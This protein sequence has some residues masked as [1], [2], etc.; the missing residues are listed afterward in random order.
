M[1]FFE[2]GLGLF[3]LQGLEVCSSLSSWSQHVGPIESGEYTVAVCYPNLPLVPST[4][5]FGVG[6]RSEHGVEDYLP[7][8]FELEI[9]HSPRS[10][11][12]HFSTIRGLLAVDIVTTINRLSATP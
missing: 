3:N 12:E 2:I 5:R 9:V 10:A 1:D 8:A 7:E 6:L 11:R 4:Y